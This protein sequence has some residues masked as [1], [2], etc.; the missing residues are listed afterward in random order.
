MFKQLIFEVLLHSIY[1]IL[2]LCSSSKWVISEVA[3]MVL[4]DFAQVC[5]IFACNICIQYRRISVST[6]L[7]QNS[8]YVLSSTT[9][10]CRSFE[11]H[12]SAPLAF[13]SFLNRVDDPAAFEIVHNLVLNLLT[14]LDL[15][16]QVT[17]A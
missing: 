5:A 15:H 9:L 10:C 4:K 1:K 7:L 3:T 14:A 2:Q 16:K 12:L 11:T 8:S 17:F 6:L 13:E